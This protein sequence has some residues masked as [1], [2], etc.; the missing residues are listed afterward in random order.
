MEK[1]SVYKKYI[2]PIIQHKV[3]L[4]ILIFVVM[5][6]VFSIWSSLRGTSFLR[7]AVFR[8]ILNSLVVTSFLAI[9][10]GFLLVGAR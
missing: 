10:A 9:G 8:N 4:L 7:F 3:F 5:V 6:I 1:T 2:A